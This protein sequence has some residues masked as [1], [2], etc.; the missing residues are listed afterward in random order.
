M[1]LNSLEKIY[2]CLKYEQPEI[3]VPEEIRLKAYEP[4]RKMLDLST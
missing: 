4:I 3:H 1:K 2:T